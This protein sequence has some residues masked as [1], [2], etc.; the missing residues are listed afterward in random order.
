MK[1]CCNVHWSAYEDRDGAKNLV[2]QDDIEEDAVH[3]DTTV[4][5]QEAQPSDRTHADTHTRRRAAQSLTTSREG[6]KSCALND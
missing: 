5:S 4:V 3:M 1:A 2:V 6:F